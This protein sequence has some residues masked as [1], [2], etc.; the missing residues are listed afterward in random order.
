MRESKNKDRR[1]K[2]LNILGL[3]LCFL[4][5]PVIVINMTMVA[6]AV[7]W[8]DV[9]PSFLGYTPMIVGAGGMTPVFGAN[10]IVIAKMPRD[11]TVLEEGTIICCL[12]QGTLTAHR[13]VGKEGTGEDVVYITQMNDETILIRVTPSQIV[14]VYAFRIPKLGRFALFMQT[15]KGIILVAVISLLGLFLLYRFLDQKRYQALLREQKRELS[16][17]SGEISESGD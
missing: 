3:I 2:V 12:S 7:I 6:Q 17:E 10:D 16:E 5:L 9:P 8:P 13:I 1:A 15:P 11:A 14:G 4:M